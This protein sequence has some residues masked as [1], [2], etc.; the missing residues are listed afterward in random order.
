ME[1]LEIVCNKTGQPLGV[2]LPREAVIRSQAWCRSTNVFVLNSKGEVLVHQRSMQKE[3]YPGVWSTHLGGHVGEGESYEINALKEL[4]EEAGVT[5]QQN[6]LVPWRTTRLEK[7]RLW[8]REFVTLHDAPVHAFIAQ[9]GEVD[10]FKWMSPEEILAA[11][12]IQPEMWIAGT[13]D[14]RT[15]YLCLRSALNAASA[16]GAVEVPIAM[17]AWQPLAL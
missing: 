17:Q 7:S 9:P 13:H 4:E 2:V 12:V 16:L 14:F 8:V 11:S 1:N 6:Q 5:K 15:E 10:Q 3:R